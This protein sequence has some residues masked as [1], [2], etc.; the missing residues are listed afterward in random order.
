MEIFFENGIKHTEFQKLY[1][2]AG[3]LDFI[4]FYEKIK[5]KFIFLDTHIQCK[6][7]PFKKSSAGKNV[8][9]NGTKYE[10]TA[11]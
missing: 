6:Y 1:S 4:F 11:P 5:S 2:K 9:R 7:N 10:K 8:A 3:N